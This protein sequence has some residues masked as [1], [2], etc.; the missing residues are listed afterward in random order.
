MVVGKQGA[1][2]AAEWELVSADLVLDEVAVH[3]AA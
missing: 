3:R 2:V 1:D